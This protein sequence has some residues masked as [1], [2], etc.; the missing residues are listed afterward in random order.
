MELMTERRGGGQTPLRCL[1]EH[2]G[3]PGLEKRGASAA[4][5]HVAPQLQ[6]RSIPEF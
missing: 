5:K 2:L 6:R 4:A 3:D 1:R